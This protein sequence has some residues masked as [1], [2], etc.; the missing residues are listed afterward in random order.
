[1]KQ[2]VTTPITSSHSPSRMVPMRALDFGVSE[3]I[4]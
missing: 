2:A 1:L 3:V 4:Q